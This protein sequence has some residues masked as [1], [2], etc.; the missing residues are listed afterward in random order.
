M[1]KEIETTVQRYASNILIARQLIET[2][3]P[4]ILS[5]FIG[6]WSDRFGR[7]P[8]ILSTFIGY[9]FIYLMLTVIA[10]TSTLVPV[11]PWWYFMA[12]LPIAFTGGYCALLTGLFCYVADVAS[13]ANRAM[14]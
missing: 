7:K 4:G 9:F 11:N 14:R 6:P 5:L 3:L 8:V 1:I 10:Y 12:F 2:V 13:Q